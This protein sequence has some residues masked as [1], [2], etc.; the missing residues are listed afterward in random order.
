M[1]K[2]NKTKEKIFNVSL[3]LFSQ[4]GYD[5]VSIREIAKN[6][7]I[8][9]SS[10]Y[11][12]YKNK[13]AILNAILEYFKKELNVEF[14]NEETL[15]IME[16]DPILFYHTGS[17]IFKSQLKKP[18]L[19]KILR[20][21]LIET[22]HNDKIRNFFMNNI[23][24]EPIT[25][26]TYIFNLMIEKEIIQTNITAK[27]LAKEYYSYGVYLILEILIKHPKLTDEI[28]N[29][30]IDNLFNEMEDH[31]NFIINRVIVGPDENGNNY[32]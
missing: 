14:P 2:Q 1:V 25:I 24:I 4:K 17:E 3:D 6:V 26:W 9:E 5:N 16:N 15:K 7:G 18:K 31:I 29:N 13:E 8:K 21:I 23:I 20:I 12:H 22:Y 19:M 32:I 10:I 28:L 30:A 11:N 27:Q